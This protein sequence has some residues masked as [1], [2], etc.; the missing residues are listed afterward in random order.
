MVHSL[1]LGAEISARDI[2]CKFTRRQFVYNLSVRKRVL[3]NP[4]DD[5]YASGSDQRERIRVTSTSSL[6]HEKERIG[7]HEARLTAL[8]TKNA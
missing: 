8:D 2:I 5:A 1:E 7:P 4:R 6:N 3:E